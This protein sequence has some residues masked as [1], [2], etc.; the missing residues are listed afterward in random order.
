MLAGTAVAATFGKGI[1]SWC[2]MAWLKMARI[3]S[4]Q[5][6]AAQT[7]AAFT[8]LGASHVWRSA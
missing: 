8:I 2:A 1:I 6:F 3:T 7:S 5:G 4:W